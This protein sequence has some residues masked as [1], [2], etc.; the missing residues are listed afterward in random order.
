MH[1]LITKDVGCEGQSPLGPVGYAYTSA[2]PG[3]IALYRCSIG[4]GADH[5]G[6]PAAGCEGQT[7]EGL[8]GYVLP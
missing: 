8:L 5:F 1:N 2:Q 6:S 4:G 3:A 7:A